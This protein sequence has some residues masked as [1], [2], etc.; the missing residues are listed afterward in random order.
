MADT[1]ISALSADASVSGSEEIPVNDGGTNKKV[2]V[3]QVKTFANTSPAFAAGSASAA[4]WP[5]LASGTKLTTPEAGA[6]EYDGDAHYLTPTASGRAVAVAENIICLSASYTLTNTASAQKL[7]NSSTNGTLTLP[8]GTYFFECLFSLSSMSGTSGNAQFQILGGG[9][10]TVG[11]VLYNAV[12][13]DGNINT[14]ATQTGSTSNASSSPAALVTAA[15]N[16]NLHALVRGT[17]RVTV[18][19]T[20]IPSIALANAAAAVVAA[21]SYFRCYKVG[22]SSFTTVGNW[23]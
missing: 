19:G 21:G 13:V 16:T 20:I 14:A 1:K 4:S 22:S 7:F 3:T 10:A 17:F 18:A 9:T 23:S 6:W 15:T 2:T 5:T 11:T 12:G 8:T